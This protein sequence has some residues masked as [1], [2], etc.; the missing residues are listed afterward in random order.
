MSK[1]F[2]I[3]IIMVIRRW[4]STVI[5]SHML[6]SSN[7]AKTKIITFSGSHHPLQFTNIVILY[8]DNYIF[9]IIKK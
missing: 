8:G 1:G 7:K 4:L 2:D 9:L 6:A 5:V 3:D